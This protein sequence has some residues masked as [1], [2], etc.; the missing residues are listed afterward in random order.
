MLVRLQVEIYNNR[1][2]CCGFLANN[3]AKYSLTSTI[4]YAIGGTPAAAVR[5]H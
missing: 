1:A 3:F 5:L 4:K 2:G